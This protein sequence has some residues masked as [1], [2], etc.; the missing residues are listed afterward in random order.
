MDTLRE[1]GLAG[2]LGLLAG[3][4]LG[5]LLRFLVGTAITRQT[6]GAFPW[7][8]LAVNILGCFAIGLVAG[9]AERQGALSTVLR[10]TIVAGLLGGFTTFSSFGLELF[11]LLSS[12]RWVPAAAYVMLSNGL[13]VAAVW[14]G[15]R[16][17]STS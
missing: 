13:G 1:P 8:T 9:W 7:G 14:A 4:A 15:F 10:M 11:Q 17:L 6:G 12:A 16:I 2:W 5:T 3:G